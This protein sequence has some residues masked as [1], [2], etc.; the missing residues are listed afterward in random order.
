MFECLA[1]EYELVI[2]DLILDSF[3]SGAPLWTCEERGTSEEEFRDA[4]GRRLC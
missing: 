3:R 4:E 1:E 2:A